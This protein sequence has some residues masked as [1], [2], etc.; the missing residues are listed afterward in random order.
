MHTPTSGTWQRA[1]TIPLGCVVAATLFA[2]SL[3]AGPASAVTGYRVIGTGGAGLNERTAPST[4][5][6]FIRNLPEGT[7]LDISCQT[8]GTTV[9]GSA[10]WDRLADGGYISDYYTTTPVYGG[11]SPGIGVCG[12]GVTGYPPASARDIGYNPFAANYSNQCTYYAEERMHQATGKY[13]PVYGNAYQWA[14][15]AAAGGWT[16][17]TAAAVNSVVVFPAG[18]FSSSVGHVAWVVAIS[19]NQLRI[20]DYNWNWVGAH[21]TDHWVTIPAGT[22]YIYSDR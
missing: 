17:G 20:Q 11:Y 8:Q 13:M 4:T 3:A 7:Q 19:G 12:S 18:S 22:H 15:Q 6:S 2:I 14:T 10:I 1:I 21:V 5:A 16:V 9:N